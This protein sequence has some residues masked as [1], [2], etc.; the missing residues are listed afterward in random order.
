MNC[1]QKAKDNFCYETMLEIWAYSAEAI[2]MEQIQ[3]L[4]LTI[5]IFWLLTIF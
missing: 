3:V 5:K 4:I 2:I 1:G